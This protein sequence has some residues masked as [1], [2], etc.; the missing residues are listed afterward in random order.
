MADG[1]GC[2][3]TEFVETPTGDRSPDVTVGA[4]EGVGVADFGAGWQ[5]MLPIVSARIARR[6][7]RAVIGEVLATA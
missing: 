1:E 2:A 4:A 3:A 6:D 7:V 5:P